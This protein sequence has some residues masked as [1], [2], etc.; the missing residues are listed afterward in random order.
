VTERTVLCYGDSN[1]HGTAPMTS[2]ADRRRL[3]RSE[4]WPG[5][6]AAELGPD[7]HVIEEGL[8]GRTTVHPDPVEG[9]Y[10][11]GLAVLPAI[12]DSHVPIDLVVLMLGTNDLKPRFQVPPVQIGTSIE[13]LLK[14]IRASE[15]GPENGAP[16]VLLI[17]PA[18]VVEE[19]SLAEIFAGGPARSG[20]AGPYAEAARRYGAMFLDAG[21]IWTVSPVD[22]VHFDVAEHGKLGRAEAAKVREMMPG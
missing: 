18:P 21:P 17:A 4:R 7:W 14:V 5:V 20:L 1:T 22:G 6:L 3:A 12:L 2:L 11:N 10:K 9:E 15:A 8:P 19:G 16:R 13:R